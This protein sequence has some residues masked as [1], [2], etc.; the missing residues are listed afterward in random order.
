MTSGGD[1]RNHNQQ[2]VLAGNCSPDRQR[3]IP[4][5]RRTHAN[6][7][8]SSSASSTRS[9]KPSSTASS[10]L[11][12]PEQHLQDEHGQPAE[13]RRDGVRQGLGRAQQLLHLLRP[14]AHA[15]HQLRPV[16]E[17]QV[18]L[19]RLRGPA[20]AVHYAQHLPFQSSAASPART[21]STPR[22][23]TTSACATARAHSS[24][25]YFCR[26]FWP[27]AVREGV[28]A[29]EERAS[30]A[31]KAAADCG[32]LRLGS[33]LG[34]GAAK[35]MEAVVAVGA[36][37]NVDAR[38][39]HAKCAEE[40]AKE[41]AEEGEEANCAEEAEQ[42]KRV[43]ETERGRRADDGGHAQRQRLQGDSDVNVGSDFDAMPDA[44]EG[45]A[46]DTAAGED[47][48]LADAFYIP[49]GVFHVARI[50]VNPRQGREDGPGSREKYVLDNR[51]GAPE[52]FVCQE[53]WFTTGG[54]KAPKTQRRLSFSVH[55]KFTEL[56]GIHAQLVQGMPS[57]WKKE[58]QICCHL[59]SALP[60]RHGPS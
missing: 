36:G 35:P 19:R 47:N 5:K 22:R 32:G 46:D 38:R 7:C 17:V 43:E 34:W 54:R 13:R 14:L 50:L 31:S 15:Q 20:V 18:V 33:N 26:D 60:L 58:A 39:R 11:H 37:A 12:V 57:C 42:T 25:T 40:A 44:G 30:S 29:V 1:F 49:N 53:Q 2:A 56:A 3:T 41:A 6:S 8:S 9:T 21:L 10:G 52:S 4:S 45:D 28:C 51:E 16:P 24:Q 48:A 23:R 55:A 27:S 59:S